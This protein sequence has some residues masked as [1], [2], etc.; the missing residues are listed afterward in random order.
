MGALGMRRREI[1][2]VFFFE[3]VLLSVL[4]AAAGSLVGGIGSLAGSFFP[5]DMTVMTGGGMKDFPISGT[6]Y[7]DFSF[8]NIFEGFFFGVIVSGLCTLIPSMK[9]AYIEPVEAL[10]R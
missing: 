4:G 7:L 10:R 5:I 2:T 1:V 8:S 6:L 9:S 3:A